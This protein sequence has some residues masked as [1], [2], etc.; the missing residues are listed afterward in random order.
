MKLLVII[1][2]LTLGNVDCR[3]INGGIECAAC[4][5]MS[6]I[7]GQLAVIHNETIYGEGLELCSK[8]PGSARS[9]CD[10]FVHLLEPLIVS[11]ST[12][13][14]FTPDVFCYGIRLCYLE[15]ET[16]RYCHLF[17]KPTSSFRSAVK[18]FEEFAS[19]AYKARN[20][21][22]VRSISEVRA[23]TR[24]VCKFPVLSAICKAV[25]ETYRSLE[26]LFDADG[27]GFSMFEDLRG[28]FWRGRDCADWESTAY[29]GR[30]PLDGDESF[31]HNCNGI[32]G[33]NQ[34]TGR[35]YETELCGDSGARGIA[36]FG[37][38]VGGHFHFPDAWLDP[39]KVSLDVHIRALLK[40]GVMDELNWPQLGYATGFMNSTEPALVQGITDSIYLRLRARNRC[41]HRDYQNLAQN[42][43][44]SF[45]IPRHVFSLARNKTVDKPLLIFYAVVGID[46]CNELSD[47][48]RRMTK[49][50]VFRRNVV[51]ALRLLDGT[52]P[53]DSHVVLIGLVDGGMIYDIMADRLHPIGQLNGDV[54]YR[55]LYRWFNCMEI[56]P[57]YGWLNENATLRKLTT[58]VA[59]QLNARLKDVAT[60]EKFRS[61]D[62][63]YLDNPIH[64]MF[65]EWQKNH[66]AWMLVEPVDSLHPTQLAQPIIT[67]ILWKKMLQYF[68][69]VLGEVNPNND[70]IEQLFKDQGGH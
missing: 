67:D 57:C 60:T 29:P 42:A 51:N 32:F 50:S 3:G 19:N 62:V 63:H 55:E 41:N 24:D 45:D 47:T 54:H 13:K 21:S 5:V 46:V 31:D 6:G 43:D 18:K 61:F 68:P 2:V 36:Y 22:A 48:L 4:T 11:R 65:H 12:L 28:T 27:D 34:A 20:R 30:R 15:E 33:T 37:D 17:P 64:E 53:E 59:L 66:S 1:S 58:K 38:S 23:L 10:T 25:N 16:H 52:V 26:P 70:K 69:H 44:S 8:L 39:F 9:Y 40:H 49:P 14:E 7:L 35:P 56:G